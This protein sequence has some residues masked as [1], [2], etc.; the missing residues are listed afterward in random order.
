MVV[1]VDFEGWFR[2]VDPDD[3][4]YQRAGDKK[5]GR[6]IISDLICPGKVRMRIRWKRKRG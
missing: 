1:V 3:G 6:E 2:F 4:Y 5:G